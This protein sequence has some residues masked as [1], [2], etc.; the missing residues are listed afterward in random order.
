MKNLI[1]A[2]TSKITTGP[3]NFYNDVG[4]RVYYRRPPQG[5]RTLPDCIISIVVD[6]PDN[7]FAKRGEDV[8]IQFSLFS[9]SDSITEMD[10]MYSDLKTLFDDVKLTVTSSTMIIMKRERLVAMN[11]IVITTNGEQDCDFWA[12]DYSITLQTT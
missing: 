7:V 3:S 12:V 8:S 10:S 1:T 5:A 6:S 11:E 4:G 2:I 9:E